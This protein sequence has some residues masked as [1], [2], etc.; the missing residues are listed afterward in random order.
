MMPIVAT[1]ACLAGVTDA[2][3]CKSYITVSVTLLLALGTL[4]RNPSRAAATRV[5]TGL[6]LI[7]APY[8]LNFWDVSP[9]T[10]VYLGCGAALTALAIPAWPRRVSPGPSPISSPCPPIHQMM[11]P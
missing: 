9:A 7:A 11:P 2:P 3:V 8:L 4:T 5:L 1:W 6:W 10:W